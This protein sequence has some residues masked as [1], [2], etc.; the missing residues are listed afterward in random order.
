[1]LILYDYD[2]V[3]K[4]YLEEFPNVLQAKVAEVE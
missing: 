1:M 3:L 2:L 4:D